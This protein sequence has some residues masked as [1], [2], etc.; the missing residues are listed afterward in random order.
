MTVGYNTYLWGDF[1]VTPPLKEHH[2][3]YLEAFNR[4]RRMKRQLLVVAVQDDPLRVAVGLP[5][6][7]EGEYYV[8]S[9]SDGDMGQSKGPGIVHYNSP[10]GSQ[11]GL[12]CPW[13]P[14]DDGARICPDGSEKPYS[15]V[16]WMEYI[17]EHFLKPW[18]YSVSGTCQWSGEDR[19]DRGIIYAEDNQ[20][21]AVHDQ[22]S[23]PGPSW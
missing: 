17:V 7:E 18:G 20:V 22:I 9:H 5:F 8:G 23:N 10:P 14:S 1:N 3:K 2:R 13:M 19:D 15:Y 12:W 4:T 11:P 16:E 21:Q 6:G